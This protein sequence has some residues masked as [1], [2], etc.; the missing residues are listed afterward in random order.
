MQPTLVCDTQK[1]LG[2]KIDEEFV[3]VSLTSGKIL[4]FN[5]ESEVF[6]RFF[7]EPHA[8]QSYCESFSIPAGERE[9]L[10]NFCEL[11]AK[12]GL[13]TQCEV[14]ESCPTAAK[15]TSYARPRFLRQGEKL[16]SQF[17]FSYP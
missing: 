8:L 10:K 6:F 5:A 2:M 17:E 14:K 1:A 13:L 9:Y 7:L 4:H 15:P 3:V 16:L 12:E 11:L